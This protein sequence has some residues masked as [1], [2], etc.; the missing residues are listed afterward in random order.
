MGKKT[1]P[2]ITH[3]I[4][5]LQDFGTVRSRAMFGGYGLYREGVMF[6]L[7][8]DGIL[9]VKAD[10]DNRKR[11]EQRGMQRFGY[12]RRG[13]MYYMSYYTVPESALEEPEILADWTGEGYAAA[14][15]ARR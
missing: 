6:A 4:E 8:A 13:R 3:I 9:Y 15:R 7:V 5:M 11:F 14:L 2:F 1:D 10:D 12:T